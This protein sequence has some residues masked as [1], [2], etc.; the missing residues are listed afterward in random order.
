MEQE[1]IALE[2][3]CSKTLRQLSLVCVLWLSI[4]SMWNFVSSI[5]EWVP[6][7]TAHHRKAA[8]RRRSFRTQRQAGICGAVGGTNLWDHSMVS[9]TQE[10]LEQLL[11]CVQATDPE[12]WAPLGRAAPN[13]CSCKGRGCEGQGGWG[14]CCCCF[15]ARCDL[16]CGAQSIWQLTLAFF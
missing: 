8:T 16:W 13:P 2:Q 5:I 6:S 9:G 7:W 12:G 3:D 10:V 14:C 11:L 4:I 1:R 15:A